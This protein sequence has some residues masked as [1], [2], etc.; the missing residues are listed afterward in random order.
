MTLL[1]I[2]SCLEGGSE[3]HLAIY[4]AVFLFLA[5][6]LHKLPAANDETETNECAPKA[7]TKKATPLRRSPRTSVRKRD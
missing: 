4:I 2:F 3:S 7:E 1:G 5:V 6:F